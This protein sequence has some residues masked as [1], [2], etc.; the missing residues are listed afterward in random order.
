MQTLRFPRTVLA[1]LILGSIIFFTFRLLQLLHYGNAALFA[2]QRDDLL[3][4][5]WVGTRF[6]LKML[7]TGLLLTVVPLRLC[8]L[9]PVLRRRAASLELPLVAILFWLINFAAICQYFY[10][11]FYQTPFTP[12]VFGFYEDDTQ[13]IIVSILDRYP[14]ALV[15]CIVFILTAVQT[16][17]TYRWARTIQAHQVP[18][19]ST[20]CLVSTIVILLALFFLARGQLGTLPLRKSDATISPNPF[21]NDLVRN[22]WQTLYDAV[23]DRY[24]QIEIGN[25]PSAQLNT[26]GFASLDELAHTLGARSGNPDDLEAFIFRRT[27]H[28]PW[29]AAHPPHIVFTLMES[30]GMQPLKLSTAK[31]DLT[32]ALGKYLKRGP[33]FENFFPSQLATHASLEA[34]LLNSPL[35][36]LPYDQSNYITYRAAAAKPFKE[37][38]YRTVFIY[39]GS[40]DWQQID[41]TM[42][43]QYFD[44]FYEESHILARYPE[45]KKNVWGVDDEYLFRFGFEILQEAE[46]R[47]EKVFLF[48]LT[49]TNHSPNQIVA[50][51]QRLPL[52]LPKLHPQLAGNIQDSEKMAWTYQYANHQLGLFLDR[53]DQ[54]RSL[55]E[56]TLVLAT[57]DHNRTFLKYELPATSKDLFSVPAYFYLPRAYRPAFTPDTKRF[58]GHRDLFPTLYNLT[59]SD[60]VYPSLGENLFTDLPSEEQF[61]MVDNKFMFS[62]EGALLPF[63]GSYLSAFQW[64]KTHTTLSLETQPR[65]FLLEQGKRARAWLALADWYTRYQVIQEWKHIS[66]TGI[67]TQP[68]GN[69]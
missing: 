53:I 44:E 12:L 15:F 41:R 3:H 4:A 54:S 30:W 18:V 26:Y 32:G 60:A 8:A 7:A 68:V 6:D 62:Q 47:G 29:L 42:S 56:K 36:P 1:V 34:L 13:A 52:D 49:M 39:G 45:A 64:D 50:D 23:K 38:G 43:H 48:L 46:K 16:Y 61:A 24:E 63:V 51:Y 66:R 40:G 11:D 37:K 20:R 65:P 33:L 5:F 28:N 17:L 35:S 10:Y 67:S 57:G 19:L 25:N 59:L 21:V 69:H 9:L 14:V 22:A 58:A 31:N 2:Q 27:P 55:K